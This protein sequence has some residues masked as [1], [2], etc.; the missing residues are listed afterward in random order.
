VLY[1]SRCWSCNDLCVI[2]SISMNKSCKNHMNPLFIVRFKRD[3]L[4]IS[5]PKERELVDTQVHL[6]DESR[7]FGT[8]LRHP[9]TSDTS[10]TS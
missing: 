6:H 8:F 4:L 1:L 9:T 10:N 7:L 3:A 5:W 2:C